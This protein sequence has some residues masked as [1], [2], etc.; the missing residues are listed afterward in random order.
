MYQPQLNEFSFSQSNPISNNPLNSYSQQYPPHNTHYGSNP[1]P[2]SSYGVGAPPYSPYALGI[3]PPM[4]QTTSSLLESTS[5][6][7][8]AL[9]P[10]PFPPNKIKLQLIVG[11]R[12]N[13]MVHELPSIYNDQRYLWG[14]TYY[15]GSYGGIGLGNGVANAL[16][17]AMMSGIQGGS[18][19]QR[20]FFSRILK[21]ESIRGLVGIIMFVLGILGWRK[22]GR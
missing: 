7:L 16:G 3:A 11:E 20:G 1:T 9:S 13:N 18:S 19:L 5:S 2:N 6:H 8:I 15:P 10:T 22:Y 21:G 14:N 17:N 4:P 12:V